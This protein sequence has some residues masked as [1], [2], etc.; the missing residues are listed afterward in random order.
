MDH[1]LA[2]ASFGAAVLEGIEVFLV[3]EPYCFTVALEK[4]LRGFL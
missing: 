1:N 3:L 4:L 2:H